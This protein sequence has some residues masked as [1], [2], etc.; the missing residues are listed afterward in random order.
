VDTLEATEGV[1]SLIGGRRVGLMADHESLTRS[2]QSITL[3]QDPAYDRLL[4]F[5]Q[6]LGIVEVARC[7]GEWAD[8]DARRAAYAA[9]LE[10]TLSP[11]LRTATDQVGKRMTAAQMVVEGLD[12][13]WQEALEVLVLATDDVE[14]A[15]L[16][17]AARRRACTW[18]SSP[19]RHPVAATRGGGRQGGLLG[20]RRCRGE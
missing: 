3:G 16:M 8:L 6:S 5:A 18:S 10:P 15:P 7:Y 4:V 1:Q 20:A 19:A 13:L 2:A 12:L 17:L 9:G 14:I 11:V